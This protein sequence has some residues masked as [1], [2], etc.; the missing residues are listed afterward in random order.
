MRKLGT[1]ELAH[2]RNVLKYNRKTGDFIWRVKRASYAGCVYPGD[3]AGAIALDKD[4]GSH[5]NIGV[6]G[7][8]YR[9]HR[10]AWFFVTGKWPKDDIDHK[11]GVRTHNW[12]KNL[13]PATRSQNNN[14]RHKLMPNNIS[15]KT[16][17]SWVKERNQWTARIVVNGK[18]T[19]LGM[20]E[21]DELDKAIAVRRAAELKYH[22]EY[23]P[24]GITV[25]KLSSK[26]LKS[27]VN[28]KQAPKLNTRNV[29]G[30]T[31]VAWLGREQKWRS[32]IKV[33]VRTFQLGVFPKDDLASA[34]KARRAGE[35][36]HLGKY[37]SK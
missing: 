13:R 5:I 10:L 30:K 28:I 15:G 7:K 24:S 12:W 32:S 22:G 17:V 3:V 11:D 18:I 26:T 33:G 37:L 14:N 21:R 23:A 16:G 2:L 4:G 35:L 19:H 1:I 27:L 31:G 6:D 8:S 9:A 36:K 25:E 34:I 29:S 20:F